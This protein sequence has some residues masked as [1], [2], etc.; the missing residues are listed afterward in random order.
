MSKLSE[1]WGAGQPEVQAISN[2]ETPTGGLARFL[3]KTSQTVREKG[4]QLV[5]AGALAAT[6][7]GAAAT[8]DAQADTFKVDA[9]SVQAIAQPYGDVALGN[10][11]QQFVVY[12]QADYQEAFKS[13]RR[14]YLA[15]RKEVGD[16]D[17]ATL[18][19]NVAQ[20][21]ETLELMADHRTINHP[22]AL[23][24]SP[25]QISSFDAPQ[26]SGGTI[27]VNAEKMEKWAQKLDIPLE[28]VATWSTLHELGHANLV[29]HEVQAE[30]GWAARLPEPLMAAA[31][32]A[33]I[34]HPAIAEAKDP[35]AAAQSAMFGAFHEAYADTYAVLS[36]AD[37]QGPQA[38]LEMVKTITQH[39]TTYEEL[40]K[41]SVEPATH[42]TGATLKNLDSWL[43]SAAGAA[44]LA[45]AKTGQEGAASEVYHRIALDRASENLGAWLVKSGME[46][47]AAESTAQWVKSDYQAREKDLLAKS[48]L[49]HQPAQKPQALQ[50]TE[51]TIK[52]FRQSA[53]EELKAHR[54]LTR[55]R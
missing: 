44:T 33:L 50:A 26:L 54:E 37:K 15:L 29:D 18:P 25:N 16:V 32:K 5:M 10:N 46:P 8:K 34:A 35:Q 38:G 17:V 51:A 43:Q 40:G 6:V 36:V 19:R 55:E 52:E 3:E 39:R 53:S 11:K 30:K 2:S 49:M 4:G 28:R 45:R 27:V 9:R 13:A 7:A 22:G 42:D 41:Y 31:E 23:M 1:F 48:D 20:A 21:R 24:A 12:S 47:Q 14:E